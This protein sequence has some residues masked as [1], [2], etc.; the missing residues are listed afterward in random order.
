MTPFFLQSYDI[1]P[2]VDFDVEVSS[3]DDD[4]MKKSV[5][6]D[7]RDG[8]ASS[9]ELIAPILINSNVSKHVDFSITDRVT[10]T[11]PPAS[12][13]RC[14]RPPPVPKWKQSSSSTD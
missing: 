6:D 1:Y 14:K 13:R 2:K 4:V 3:G 12:G 7:A 10:S 8:R 5:G 9:A 11:D